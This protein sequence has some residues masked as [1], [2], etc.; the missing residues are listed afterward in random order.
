MADLF[1]ARVGNSVAFWTTQRY[2]ILLFFIKLLYLCIARCVNAI[3]NWFS[4]FSGNRE[5]GNEASDLSH[6]VVDSRVCVCFTP[7]FVY[8]LG[9]Y[10]WLWLQLEP[11]NSDS[12]RWCWDS[13]F[14]WR[15]RDIRRWGNLYLFFSIFF[16]PLLYMKPQCCVCIFLKGEECAVKDFKS[17]PTPKNF[18]KRQAWF[19]SW[20]TRLFELM[21]FCE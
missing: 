4:S 20:W 3:Q 1:T 19:W 6:T 16:F 17:R 15:W 8:N 5:V 12:R 2:L 18:E 13:R 14:L 21:V 7:P 9:I 11:N 10:S